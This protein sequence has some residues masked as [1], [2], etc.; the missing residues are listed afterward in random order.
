MPVF[1]T[2]SIDP[3]KNTKAMWLDPSVS[4]SDCF[5]AIMASSVYDGLSFYEVGELVNSIKHDKPEILLPRAEYEDMLHKKGLGRFFT[6]ISD[7]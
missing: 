2:E 5:K 3:T 7:T 1:L 6:K 4:F